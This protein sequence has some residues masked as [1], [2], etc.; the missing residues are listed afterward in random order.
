MLFRSKSP[1]EEPGADSQP[2]VELLVHETFQDKLGEQWRLFGGDWKYG[3]EGLSQN[4]DGAQR[5]V[6]RL[7]TAAPRDFEATLKF[8][9]HGGS[10]WRSIGFSFDVTTADPTQPEGPQDS[11]QNVYASAYAQGPKV[12]AAWHR[13]GAWQFPGEGASQQIGRAHV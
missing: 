9:I 13:G 4:R 12:Q 2:G 11:E 1:A 8:T 5:S 6:L 7:L 10:Q 3:A